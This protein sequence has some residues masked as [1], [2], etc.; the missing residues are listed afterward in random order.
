M[1][2]KDCQRGLQEGD[3]LQP[4]SALYRFHSLKPLFLQRCKESPIFKSPSSTSTVSS[5]KGFALQKVL[6][7]LWSS[8]FP[9]KIEG[10]FVRV[11]SSSLFISVHRDE[12]LLNHQHCPMLQSSTRHTEIIHLTEHKMFLHQSWLAQNSTKSRPVCDRKAGEVSCHSGYWS[13]RCKDVVSW[14]KSHPA[15]GDSQLK[16]SFSSPERKLWTSVDRGAWPN[17]TSYSKARRRCP[18]QV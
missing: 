13:G 2:P 14:W 11:L 18:Q 17:D 12:A 10:I 9:I 4:H 8:T 1:L 16:Q 5:Q 3:L 6:A 15:L 7:I